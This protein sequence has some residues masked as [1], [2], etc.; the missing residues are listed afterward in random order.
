MI[1]P[2]SHFSANTWTTTALQQHVLSQLSESI[3]NPQD[4]L[5]KNNLLKKI[6]RKMM[7]FWFVFKDMHLSAGFSIGSDYLGSSLRN[8][9]FAC[10]CALARKLRGIRTNSITCWLYPILLHQVCAAPDTIDINNAVARQDGVLRV[11]RVVVLPP[12]RQQ[13]QKKEGDDWPQSDSW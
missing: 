6:C 10:V 9:L 2:S 3:L 11:V 8:T 12:K 7:E 5:S 1:E 13:E 4:A